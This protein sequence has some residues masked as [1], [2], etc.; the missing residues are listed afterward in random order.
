MWTLLCRDLPGLL[1]ERK[2]NPGTGHFVREGAGNAQRFHHNLKQ[3]QKPQEWVAPQCLPSPRGYTSIVGRP[4]GLTQSPGTQQAQARGEG[5]VCTTLGEW[6]GKVSG[7][8]GVGGHTLQQ[9]DKGRKALPRKEKGD[10]KEVAPVLR[11]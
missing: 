7:W 10:I 6:H 5:C 2:E 9:V 4:P 3:D 8:H 1:K 11:P